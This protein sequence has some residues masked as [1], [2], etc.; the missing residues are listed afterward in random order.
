MTQHSGTHIGVGV[1]G[2]DHEV[3]DESNNHTDEDTAEDSAN[4][5]AHDPTAAAEV[6]LSLVD[7]EALF[8]VFKKFVSSSLRKIISDAGNFIGAS[9]IDSCGGPRARAPMTK[10]ISRISTTYFSDVID[11]LSLKKRG[12]I[13]SYGFRCLLLFDKCTVPTKFARWVLDH[14]HTSKSEI[15]FGNKSIHISPQIVNDILGIPIG[16]KTISKADPESWKLGFLSAMKLTALPSARAC[17][18]KLLEDNISDDEIVRNFLVV[19]LVTFLCP[20]SRSVPSTEYLEPLVNVKEAK[21]WDWSKFVHYWLFKQIAKYHKRMKGADLESTT[22]GGCM[23][24]I[25]VAYLD[26]L[27]VGNEHLPLTLPRTLV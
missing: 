14:V 20:N 24:I 19:A 6:F 25:C 11:S 2:C 7:D 3:G 1:L 10:A 4:V 8:G 5:E 9:T 27:N 21:D 17:G 22:M 13:E 15:V 26:F 16:G 18:E 23:Y 12:I